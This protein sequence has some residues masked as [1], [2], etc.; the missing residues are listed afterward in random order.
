MGKY[1][2]L[3]LYNKTMRLGVKNHLFVRRQRNR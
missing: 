3:F 2:D 1:W